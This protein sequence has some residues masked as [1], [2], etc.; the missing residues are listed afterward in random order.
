MLSGKIIIYCGMSGREIE[1]NQHK[2]KYGLVTRLH[3]HTSGRLSGDQFC[4]YVA[5]RIV[6]PKVSKEQ[7]PLFEAGTLTLDKLTKSFINDSLQYQYI[8]VTSSQEAYDI[9][10]QARLGLIFKSNKSICDFDANKKL[11]SKKS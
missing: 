11:K 6:I 4:V 9:E 10:K 5:N 1:K 2:K 8:V 3:S 7:L